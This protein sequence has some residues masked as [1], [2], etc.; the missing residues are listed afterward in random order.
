MLKQQ[1]SYEVRAEQHSWYRGLNNYHAIQFWGFLIILIVQ[2]TPT[3]YSNCE[4]PCLKHRILEPTTCKWGHYVL[5]PRCRCCWRLTLN[6]FAVSSPKRCFLDGWSNDPLRAEANRRS[7]NVC[8]GNWG[9]RLY[10][11]PL[12]RAWRKEHKDYFNTVG[13]LMIGMGFWGF[14]IRIIVYYTPKP[15]SNH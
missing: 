11:L 7:A 1:R 2:Y 9:F 10:L 12:K 6:P 15:Y 14:L 5:E 3:P 8:C 4:G 13:A